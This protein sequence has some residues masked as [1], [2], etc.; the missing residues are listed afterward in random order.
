MWRMIRAG[1]LGVL[2]GVVGGALVGQISYGKKSMM[3]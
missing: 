3:I 1:I 2:F